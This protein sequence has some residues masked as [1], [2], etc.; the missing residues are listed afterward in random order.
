MNIYLTCLFSFSLKENIQRF[1]D[2]G[3]V[4][5]GPGQLLC[6]NIIHMKARNSLKGWSESTKAVL[7]EVEAL[8]HTSVSFPAIGTGIV[9]LNSYRIRRF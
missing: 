8:G 6:Q 2:D 7:A 1:K 3:I 9:S 4:V 5:T